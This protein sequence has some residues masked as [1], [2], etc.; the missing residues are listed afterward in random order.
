MFNL[1]LRD[2]GKALLKH[3]ESRIGE[4]LYK[5]GLGSSAD[6]AL[7]ACGVWVDLPKPPEFEDTRNLIVASE[8]PAEGIIAGKLFPIG[9]WQDSYTHYRYY[10]RVFAFSEFIEQTAKAG[11]L[12]M[13][14]VIGVEDHTFYER[15][16][17]KRT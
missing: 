4:Y 7:F 11:R 5:D 8:I 2:T 6:M 12:A 3:L 13:Q 1:Q 14:E 15:I 16:R 9:Q 17:R 10:V